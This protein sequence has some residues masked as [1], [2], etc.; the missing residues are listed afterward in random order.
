MHSRL[1]DSRLG[2]TNSI[3]AIAFSPNAKLI[4]TS[5]YDG[6][7]KVWDVASQSL[8]E[9]LCATG[10]SGIEQVVFLPAG[11]GIAFCGSG[12][13]D[14]GIFIGCD[15]RQATAHPVPEAVSYVQLLSN[16]AALLAYDDG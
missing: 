6:T 3:T 9:T 4:A 10:E 1:G 7:V 5:S 8:R 16:G 14:D 15:E 2:H 11:L 12:S 13:C